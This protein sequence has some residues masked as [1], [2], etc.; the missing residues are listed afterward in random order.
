MVLFD[1]DKASRLMEACGID[2]LLPNSLLNAGYLADHWK[3]E[4]VASFGA[5]LTGDDGVPYL[6]LVGL[7]RD[8]KVEPF[9]TCRTGGEENDMFY[10]GVWIEDK[11]RWGPALPN[12]E[13]T[14]PFGPYDCVYHDPLEAAAAALRERSLDRGTIGLEVRFLGVEFYHRLESLLPEARLVDALPLLNELRMIKSDE[15]VRRMRVAAQA[16]EQATEAAFASVEEG[17]TG[18]DLERVIGASH[19]RAG[20]RHEWCHTCIGPAGVHID[21]PNDTPVRPGDVVRLDVGSSYR[22]YQSDIS[23]VG[24]LGEPSVELLKAHGA[25]RKALEVVIE[26]ARPGVSAEHLYEVGNSVVEGEGFDNYLTIVGHG[27][28]RDVHEMPFLQRG[29]VTLLEPGMT[30]TVELVTTLSDLGCIAVEDEIVIVPDGSEPLS[31][32]GRELYIVG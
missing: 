10:T 31:T 7:P 28:G 25:M 26:T 5:Y 6:F 19:Y 21:C 20:V 1:Y 18:R 16:T 24:V 3:H 32:K 22:H 12:R 4:L 30:F 8:Q 23:R 29:D 13:K 15:E 27:L 2:V 17:C 11:R 14:A 9:V